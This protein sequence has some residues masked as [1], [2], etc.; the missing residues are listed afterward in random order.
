M[1]KTNKS[2][3]KLIPLLLILLMGCKKVPTVFIA[4]PTCSQIEKFNYAKSVILFV[5]DNETKINILKDE[6]FLK[7]IKEGYNFIIINKNAKCKTVADLEK[8][9]Q[10]EYYPTII[11]TNEEGKE[12]Y[13]AINFDILEG[14]LPYNHLFKKTEYHLSYFSQDHKD[15]NQQKI[16]SIEDGYWLTTGNITIFDKSI[17]NENYVYLGYTGGG[18]MATKN[19]KEYFIEKEAVFDIYTKWK[20]KNKYIFDWYISNNNKMICYE[21]EAFEKETA[22]I[23]K[24]KTDTLDFISLNKNEFILK[25]D[26]M[27][28][29]LV[30]DTTRLWKTFE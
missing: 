18:L 10:I 21:I 13:R 28:L 2:L 20:R 19:N 17:T 29:K 25:K 12:I 24:I 30:R 22:L 16:D 14:E 4:N 6:A 23:P 15:L 5:D 26:K 9:F 11:S 3:Q 1:P 7:E 27:E 8:K